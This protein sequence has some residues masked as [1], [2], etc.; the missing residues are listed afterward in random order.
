MKACLLL[1]TLALAACTSAPINPR[2]P[3]STSTLA[4]YHWQLHDAVDGHNQRLDALF[5]NTEK[6]LQLDFSVDRVSVLNA[7]NHING[8]YTIVEGHLVVAPLQQ[9]MMACPEPT[10]MQREITI[11][12]VLQGGPTLILSTADDTPLLTLAAD[13]GQSL[14]FTGKPTAE[15]RYGGPGETV[16]LEVAPQM[17]SCNH[18]LVPHKSCLQVRERHYD[19]QGLHSGQPGPWQPLQ[20]DIEGYAHPQDTRNVLR[21]KRYT[22]KQPPADAPSTVYVLDM[23]VESEIVKP[24]GSVDTSDQPRHL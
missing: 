6:P 10:L 11:K 21:V 22:L 16:F 15:T 12:S 14:T 8:N 18:P 17:V 5:G 7:C 2:A 9:T 19:A 20:Q 23:V 4:R 3:I 13:S 1:L 24:S